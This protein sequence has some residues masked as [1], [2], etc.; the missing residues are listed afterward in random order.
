M[1]QLLEITEVAGILGVSRTRAY[2]LVRLGLLPAVHLGRQVRVSSKALE[3]WIETG[4]QPIIDTRQEHQK[5]H[6]EST[7]TCPECAR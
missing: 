6:K 7:F 2:A 1:V 4:G 5:Q 3:A